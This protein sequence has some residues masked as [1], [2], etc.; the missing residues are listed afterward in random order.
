[1]NKKPKIFKGFHLHRTVGQIPSGFKFHGIGDSSKTQ[2]RAVGIMICRGF[3]QRLVQKEKK[4]HKALLE[5]FV[6][7]KTTILFCNSSLVLGLT[8]TAKKVKCFHNRVGG[9]TFILFLKF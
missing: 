7:Q 1:M 5:N 3:R 8:A 2:R 4:G 9:E 6:L